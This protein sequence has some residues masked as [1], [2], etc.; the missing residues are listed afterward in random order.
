MNIIVTGGA[1]FIGSNFVFHMLNTYPDYRIIMKRC[2]VTDNNK[3]QQ[4]SQPYERFTM[5]KANDIITNIIKEVLIALYQPFGAAVLMAFVSMFVFLYAKEHG[6]KKGSLI[7]NI[8]GTWFK[9]F[10]ESS[11]FRRAFLLVFYSTMILFRTILNRDIWFD[12]LSDVMG[13]W[14]LY[15]ADGNLTT[16]AIENLILFIPF[17]VL[18]LWA[19]RK[20]LL[21]DKPGLKKTLWVAIKTVGIFSFVIEFSQLLFH[22]GTFQISDLVYNTL[23]GTIGGLMYY[24]IYRFRHRN[25][26]I[27]I[28]NGN[29][30]RCLTLM[31]RDVDRAFLCGLVIRKLQNLN[32]YRI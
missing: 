27:F 22:L 17:A 29:S 8:F 20:E 9:N 11:T 23:G 18:L 4:D 12:P 10:K 2:M 14:G 6:W 28:L 21:G 7:K 26:Q 15:D 13:G 25:E 32:V 31:E 19:F 16:E 5:D 3:L 24:V 30:G 1:G